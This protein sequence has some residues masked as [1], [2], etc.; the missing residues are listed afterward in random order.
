MPSEPKKASD[1]TVIANEPGASGGDRG[2][3]EARRSVAV[4]LRGSRGL[5]GVSGGDAVSFLHGIL[6]NDIVAL[7]PGRAL[8]SAYLTPQGRMVSD[9]RVIRRESDL[10][11]EVE[12][13]VHEALARRLDQSLFTEDVRI[14]DRSAAT[15]SLAVC[16]PDAR[17]SLSKLVG[18]GAA[19]TLR[20]L[21]ADG[22]IAVGLDDA[23]LLLL[24]SSRLGEVPSVDVLA[25][26]DACDAVHTHLVDAGVATLSPQAAE[27]L[28][29]EAGTPIFG[30]DMAE[31]TI[32]LEAGIEGRAISMTKGCY[33]GQ[34]VIV[35]ILHR[36]GGR[37]ARR[38]VGLR[39][40]GTIPPAPGA[41]LMF[42][43]KPAGHVTS[44]T[45]SPRL[46]VIA[47]GY[48]QRDLAAPGSRVVVAET[49]Q[50]AIV[51]RL[52]LGSEAHT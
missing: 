45:A 16:G 43:G 2:Y 47:L 25:R 27:A 40:E 49:G 24:G 22:W 8:Y 1:A 30:I 35:R 39:I 21:P 23:E 46:G 41:A 44:A 48:V 32:P 11:L 37:V 33:V 26:P 18:P 20:T 3:D 15:A 5:I 42:D 51:E 4:Q 10:L 13:P 9:M 38:L 7:A 36:G 31:D 14:E 52:P 17:E 6:T 12:P 50:P 28:R 29:I 34:E 19:D